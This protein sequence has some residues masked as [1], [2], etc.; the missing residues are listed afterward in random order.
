MCDD[1]T[2]RKEDNETDIEKILSDTLK[3]NESLNKENLV[4]SEN[5]TPWKTWADE[6]FEI[7]LEEATASNNGT[8][9]NAFFNVAAANKIKKR[10]NVCFTFVNWHY[11]VLFST[12]WSNSNI[13][14]CRVRIC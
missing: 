1:K 11:E 7:T 9:V 5:S 12:W 13:C 2:D 10:F 4:P 8:I 6:L 3:S 14:P